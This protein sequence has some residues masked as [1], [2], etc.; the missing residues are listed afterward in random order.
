MILVR[1]SRASSFVSRDLAASDL[2]ENRTR[3]CPTRFK[4]TRQ[5]RSV[6]TAVLISYDERGVAPASRFFSGDIM[7]TLAALCF[8]FLLS[9]C[10]TNPAPPSQPRTAS[11]TT[12]PST[13]Q[14]RQ[15]LLAAS[16]KDFQAHQPY[17]A[18]FR[19]VKL[20]HLIGPD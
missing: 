2:K 12:S 8:A 20:G 7:R 14:A 15:Y 6:L 19:G 18:Q 4:S 16:A 1:R 17:P 11:A 3:A 10:G 13:D 5:A 9:G